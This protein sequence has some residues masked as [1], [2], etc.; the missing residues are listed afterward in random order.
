MGKL[1]VLLTAAIFFIYGLL[2]I[3]FPAE[4]FKYVTGGAVSS[5]SGV[6]DMRATY[7]GMSVG[8]GV[9]LCIL[10]MN[11]KTIKL[12]LVS[13]SVLMLG[14]AA[15]RLIGIVYDGNPNTY[16]YVYLALELIVSFVSFISVRTYAQKAV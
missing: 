15:G 4:T 10:G 5:T 6:T 11:Q 16:M 7:G 9:I 1:V 8:V 2:F 3:V 13:V 14:M 12:G